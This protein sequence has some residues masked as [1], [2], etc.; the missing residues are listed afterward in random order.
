MKRLVIILVVLVMGIGTSIWYFDIDIAGFIPLAAAADKPADENGSPGSQPDRTKKPSVER[1]ADPN[2][3]ARPNSGRSGRPG[4]RPDG[5]MRPPEGKNTD[6]N[7]PPRPNSGR[8]RPEKPKAKPDRIEDPNDPFVAINLN[9]IEMKNILP[10]LAAWTGKVIIPSDLAMKARITIFAGNQVPRSEA[11]SL[12][13][14]ALR[15]KNIVAEISDKKIF[16]KPL[17]QAKTG[18]VPV[19]SANEPLARVKNK[20][21]IVEKYFKLKNISPSKLVSVI[22]PLTASYGHVTAFEDSRSI[23]VIDTV[24]NLFRIEQTIAQLDV[25]EYSKVVEQVFEIKN[26]DAIEIVQVLNLILN[27]TKSGSRSKSSSRPKPTRPSTSSKGGKTGAPAT[28]VIIQAG[29][30]Q[31]FLLPVPKHNWIIARASA[32]DMKK[33]KTWIAK[34]DIADT[35]PREQT[36][37]SIVYVEPS[38]VVRLVRNTIQSMPGSQLQ[39][40]VVVEAMRESKQVVVFGSEENRKFV[41]RLIIEIDLPVEDIYKSKDFKLKFADPDEVKTN[42]EGFY[43]SQSGSFSS[44]SY[45]RGSYSSRYRRVDP[46]DVVKVMSFP[47]LKQISVVATEENLKKIEAQIKEWDIPLDVKK[48]QYLLITLKNSDP[49]QMVELLSTLFSEDSEGSSGMS[50]MRMIFGGRDQMDSKKKIVGTL[51]GLLTF[52]AVPGTKKILVISKVPEAYEVIEAL[53]KDLDSQEKGEAPK[54][55]TL[56]YADP[57]ELCDQL[58][59][60]LNERGTVA[61]LK[62]KQQGLT[63]TGYKSTGDTSSNSGNNNNNNNQ[64]QVDPG[65]IRPWWDSGRDDETEM[66]LSNL[67]GKVRFVPVHRSKAI[68]VIAQPEYYDDIEAMVKKLDQPEMQVMIE[69]VIVEVD[70]SSMTSLG[71]QLSSN[72]SLFD[73]IGQNALKAFTDILYKKDFTSGI[74]LAAGTNINVLIDMLAKTVNAK[75]L[76][77]PN[78][79]TKDNEEAVFFKGREISIQTSDQS[80]TNSEGSRISFKQIPIGVTLRVRPNI[81][82][83][84]DVDITIN[85]EISD[86]AS[87]EVNDQPVIN[88]LNTETNLIIADGETIMLGGILFQNESE[89]KT[90]VPLL[91]DIPL[92]GGLFSHKGT[93]KRNS[94]LLIFLTPHVITN[95]KS[96]A[97]KKYIIEAKDNVESLTDPK[98]ESKYISNPA[99]RMQDIRKSLNDVL[100]KGLMKTN[101]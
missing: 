16:L 94:E 63:L 19:L 74:T 75:V 76:N 72:P 14:D 48:N 89:I 98:N 7:R 34:L 39:T 25:P 36:I 70:H 5:A 97:A 1:N 40:S 92:V 23:A 93:F 26:G 3:P 67:I 60:I 58:N 42:L 62:R 68:L 90:K 69:A 24:E 96:E 51:Y 20:S 17:T 44:S 71:V 13:Y 4:S 32:E 55:I 95:K 86:L 12:I 57:E 85:L 61:E 78:L 38:E 37:I 2:G 29:Q 46:K 84:K 52:E 65:S 49:V 101:R 22:T 79:W 83:A 31:V 80:F 18:Y 11:L 82:P 81:T 41:E 47:A 45:S 6:P 88:K 99:Q 9:N 54:V 87:E 53:V 91:G 66:P 35:S 8:V 33:I 59:A 15:A 30:T 64:Q 28:S 50:L 77:Q 43:D 56:N 21:Q 10:K 27:N 73:P 100:L